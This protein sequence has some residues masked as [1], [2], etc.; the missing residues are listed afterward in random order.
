V[1]FALQ[2]FFLTSFYDVVFSPLLISLSSQTFLGFNLPCAKLA[3]NESQNCSFSFVKNWVSQLSV[4]LKL[5]SF[6][7]LWLPVAFLL[8]LF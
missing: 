3:E 4:L 5:K 7:F 2:N 6:I 8:W 1:F